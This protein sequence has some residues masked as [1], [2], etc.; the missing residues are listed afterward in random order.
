MCLRGNK[1]LQPL[2]ASLKPISRHYS[3]EESL[4]KINKREIKIQEKN[5]YVS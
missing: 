1:G 3:L 4:I 5:G 2:A